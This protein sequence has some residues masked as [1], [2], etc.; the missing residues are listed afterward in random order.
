MTIP[1]G[2]YLKQFKASNQYCPINGFVISAGG[3]SASFRTDDGITI[4]TN[5]RKI[6]PKVLTFTLTAIM[7][8]NSN[9]TPKKTDFVSK[10]KIH[11]CPNERN[12]VTIPGKLGDWD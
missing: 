4:H 5:T 10:V 12:A 2:R 11:G 3:D 1:W 7:N 9:G 8:G 6:E